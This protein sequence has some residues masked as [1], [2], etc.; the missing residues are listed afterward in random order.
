MQ[1]NK[2]RQNDLSNYANCKSRQVTWRATGD[3][4]QILYSK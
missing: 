1:T 3:V 2:Q 4:Q